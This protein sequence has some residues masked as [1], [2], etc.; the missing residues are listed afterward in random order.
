MKICQ[1]SLAN[2]FSTFCGFHSS[3]LDVD[4]EAPCFW[5]AFVC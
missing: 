1:T 5:I 2:K 3:L 4:Q